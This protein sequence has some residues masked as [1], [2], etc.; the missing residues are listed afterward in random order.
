MSYRTGK[1]EKNGLATDSPSFS[2][3]VIIMISSLAQALSRRPSEELR[4][5]L[6]SARTAAAAAR[7]AAQRSQFEV[8]V[9]EEALSEAQDAP[10]PKSP[11]AVPP[12]DRRTPQQIR[13]MV[14]RIVEE[15]GPV[16]PKAV[17]EAIGD[18]SINVYNPLGRLLREGKL[19]REGSI[20][21]IPKGPANGHPSEVSAAVQQTSPHPTYSPEGG[22]R[23]S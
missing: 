10:T 3:T 23:V 4:E 12:Q 15:L 13:D 6:D 11:A 7:A 9:I 17:K 16:P 20:Y 14:L 18:D 19:T 22:L 21:D 2:A 1:M 5:M 8:E